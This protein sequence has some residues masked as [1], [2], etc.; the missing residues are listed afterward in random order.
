MIKKPEL[1]NT[2]F[3]SLTNCC[4]RDFTSKEILPKE[5]F[6]NEATRDYI[7]K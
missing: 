5:A 3:D 4:L 1:L 7:L 2:G 6:Y